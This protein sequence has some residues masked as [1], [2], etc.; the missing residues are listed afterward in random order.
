VKRWWQRRW[1][2][3]NAEIDDSIAVEARGGQKGNQCMAT[4]ALHRRMLL[5]V[6]Q[7]GLLADK[8]NR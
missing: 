1:G 5:R 8:N 4:V 7:N 6:K 3:S 2:D